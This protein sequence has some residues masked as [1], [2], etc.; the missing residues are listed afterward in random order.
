MIFINTINGKGNAITLPSLN[1]IKFKRNLTMS[2]SIYT[3][4]EQ[5]C[6]ELYYPISYEAPADISEEFARLSELHSEFMKNINAHND[7]WKKGVKA[8]AKAVRGTT[9]TEQHK[10]RKAKSKSRQVTIEGITYSSGKLAAETLGY[11]TST[12][13]SWIKQQGRTNINIPKG[14]NQ[15]INR[16]KQSG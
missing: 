4:S 12:I 9:Q 3:P 11:S 13:S 7:Y 16:G 14:S 15:Y 8:A 6:K 5:F 2:K 10:A 1:T